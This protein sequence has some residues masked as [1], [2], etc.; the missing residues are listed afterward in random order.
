MMEC[1]IE[2][3][4]GGNILIK[5]S[6][7]L[8]SLVLLASFAW[9]SIDVNV[10]VQQEIFSAGKFNDFF[11]GISCSNADDYFSVG[12]LADYSFF[13]CMNDFCSKAFS[14]SF[15]FRPQCLE[16]GSFSFF[17]PDTV[18]GEIVDSVEVAFMAKRSIDV[19]YPIQ[20]LFSFGGAFLSD[21]NIFFPVSIVPEEPDYSFWILA[22][23]IILVIISL[24]LMYFRVWFALFPFV[25]GLIL[26]VIS[27]FG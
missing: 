11:Y 5:F 4:D 25:A 1:L 26:V 12:E 10:V 8:V 20:K 15:V 3:S 13:V 27:V 7:V 2:I 24:I 18:K 17:V 22:A 14:S 6:L 16:A 23:G 21:E 19:S 9:A